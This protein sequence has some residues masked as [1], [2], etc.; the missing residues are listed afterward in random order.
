M[1]VINGP[2]EDALPYRLL[3]FSHQQA[4]GSNSKDNISLMTQVYFKVSSISSSIYMYSA[5]PISERNMWTY[6]QMD[7][8]NPPVYECISRKTF[9]LY[10]TRS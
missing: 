1:H 3:Q 2:P 9:T 7:G 10:I 5:G 4:G 8:S 6:K